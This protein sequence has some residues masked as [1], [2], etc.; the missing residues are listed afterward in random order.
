MLCM[1]VEGGYGGTGER[2]L[3]PICVLT[4]GA[5]VKWSLN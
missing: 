1:C 5:M 4:E 3:G 2:K